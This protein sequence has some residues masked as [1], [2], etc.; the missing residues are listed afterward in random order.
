MKEKFWLF[1]TYLFGALSGIILLIYGIS[2]KDKELKKNSIISI[3]LSVIGS[4]LAL[5]YILTII[6]LL[7][8]LYG[9]YVGYK[10]YSG[11]PIVIP[12]ISEF[13]E[14]LTETF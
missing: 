10:A 5:T 12:Y 9:L 8:Y 13:A 6:S 4:L 11:K 7:I 14:K 2:I 3:T 1:V